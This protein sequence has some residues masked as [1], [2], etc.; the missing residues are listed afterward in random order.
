[1]SSAELDPYPAD[2]AL[3][4]AFV[5][6][7]RRQLGAAEA[8][9]AHIGTGSGS[10]I[11]T[12]TAP[13][14][15]RA[16]L[17]RPAIVVETGTPSRRRQALLRLRGLR[18]QFSGTARHRPTSPGLPMTVWDRW[19]RSRL[20][21]PPASFTVTAIM[22]TFN[23]AEIVDRQLDR[24]VAGGLHVHVVDNWS[25]DD[26][27]ARVQAKAQD[28]PITCERWPE[29]GPSPYF[30]LQG[31]LGKVEQVARTCGADWV[32]HHDADEI[33]EP[34][35]PRTAMR[36][37]LWA[38]EHWGFNAVDHTG[39]D[40]RP[41]EDAWHPGEDLAASFEWFEFPPFSSYFTLV[42]AW[43]PGAA[44]VDLAG[45]GGHQAVFAGRR[46]FPYKFLLRHYPIRS[47]AHGERKVLGERKARFDPAERAQGWHVQY[48]E[49]EEG[50]RFLW[51][52]ADLHRWDQLDEDFFVQRLSG[53]GLPAN[54][55]PEE[56]GV[57]GATPPGA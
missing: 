33:H 12:R 44:P 40:F 30:R 7:L 11:G 42:R 32:V 14:A 29:D 17:A 51:D 57:A 31:L 19:D 23:E 43:K 52:P 34:P 56:S 10:G 18:P 3:V 16:L 24:L 41:V 54:P 4:D 55:R 27:W 15:T 9:V 6:Y 13:R 22:C 25:T 5:H 45:T 50:A 20:P 35:W 53:A 28:A 49:F 2:T 47:Q 21:D 39:V 48:D 1:M 38:L 46:V 8:E 37:A 36:D 26:T